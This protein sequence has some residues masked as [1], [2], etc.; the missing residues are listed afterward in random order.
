M[1]KLVLYHGSSYIIEKP[2]YGQGKDYNDYGRG[3]YCTKHLELAK[4][5]ACTGDKDGYANKYEI[6]MKNMKVLDLQSEEYDILHWLT[7]LIEYRKFRV[8]TPSMKK[9]VQWL[10]DNFHI[11]IE[12]Y[13]I[14]RG[15]RADDSYFSFARAFLNNEISLEQLSR[16]MRLGDLGEQIVL[17]SKKAFNA[18][19]FISFEV[20]DN[21]VYYTK[22]KHRDDEA[23]N[24]YFRELEEDLM[25]GIY[26]RDLIKGGVETYGLRI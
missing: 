16:A 21:N 18:V 8:T 5:W 10:R 11:D 19:K 25:D 20:A 2:V 23:K 13:D 17:K 7:L 12:N 14:I 1:S 22:R 15:Y 24:A 9:S 6:D 3:F 26:I 4:E